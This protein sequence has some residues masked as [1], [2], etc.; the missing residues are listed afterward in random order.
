ML[1]FWEASTANFS[2]YLV[3]DM[4]LTW[5]DGSWGSVGSGSILGSRHSGRLVVFPDSFVS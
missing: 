5:P 1:V 4:Q 3:I 2:A